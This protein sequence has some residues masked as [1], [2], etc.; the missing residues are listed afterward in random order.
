MSTVTRHRVLRM[1]GRDPLEPGRASTALEL[2][3]DL[4]FV[5]AFGTAASAFSH[6][7][8]SGHVTDGIIS[9]LFATF[10]VSWAWINFSW[11]ASAYDTDDWVFRI[12]TMVQMVGVLVLALGLPQMFASIAAGEHVNNGV[13]VFGYVIMRIAMVGQWARAAHQD[14]GRRRACMAYIVTIL[15]AQAGWIVLALAHTSVQTML[16]CVAVLIAIELAGPL[17]AETRLGGTPWHPHHIAERYALLVI[18]TLGE[19]L[20]GT[21]ATL[22]GLVDPDQTGISIPFDTAVVGLAGVGLTFGMWWIY[23]ILPGGEILASRR[24]RSFGW[25]YGHMFV[26]GAIVAV[27]AGIHAAA[28]LIEGESELSPLSTLLCVAIPLAVY[29]TAVYLLYS[30]L[31]RSVDIFHGSL[32]AGSSGVLLGALLLN[33]AGASIVW[34]LLVMACVPWVT[35]IGNE[36][37]GYR[38]S[39]AVLA[40]L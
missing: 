4:T 31:T 1:V 27:G 8:V 26:F 11:F 36:L 33:A 35:V 34:C 16:A 3:F 30:V 18:V 32:V 23:F 39:E 2:L 17:I 40:E 9:F 24:S 19:A 12:M 37:R 7:L 22:I 10:A 14:P 28:Y 5:I 20:I 25:G 13:M 6:E 21:M 38:H 29:L 15:V